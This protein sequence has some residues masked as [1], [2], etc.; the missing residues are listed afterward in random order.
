VRRAH[1]VDLDGALGE[2][3]QRR[4]LQELIAHTRAAGGPRLQVAGGLRDRAAIEEALAAGADRVVVG[5]LLARD[6]DLAAAL[7]EEHPGRLVPALDLRGDT[8]QIAGW[9]EDA[10]LPLAEL[11][12]RLAPLPCPAVLVTDVERDGTL[13]GVNL[14]IARRV[15]HGSGLPALVSG[16][17]RSLA[18]L[19]AARRYPEIGGVVVGKALLEGAF[20]LDQA[21]AVLNGSD[22]GGEDHDT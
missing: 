18:D 20:T 3:P 6:F 5:S 19:R 9:R 17:V 10:A 14:A 15:G 2:A 12:R 21:L 8:V 7:A 11:C 13:E 1:L 16:G 22:L 4:R